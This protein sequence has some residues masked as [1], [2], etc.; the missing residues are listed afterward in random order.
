MFARRNKQEAQLE[1]EI[2]ELD[3]QRLEL[4]RELSE[5]NDEIKLWQL[6]TSRIQA[7]LG[8]NKQEYERLVNEISA[9]RNKKGRCALGDVEFG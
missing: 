1:R 2:T 4:R 5:I 6:E 7:L 9:L 8:G 3:G